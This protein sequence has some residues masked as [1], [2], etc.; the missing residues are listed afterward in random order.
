VRVVRMSCG[1]LLTRGIGRSGGRAPEASAG[2]PY[3]SACGNPSAP[4][5]GTAAFGVPDLVVVSGHVA[6]L[7]TKGSLLVFALAGAAPEGADRETLA[8]A[9]IDA[10]GD[11][12]I[13]MLPAEA[14]AFAFL[15]DGANDGVID[16]GDPIAVLTGPV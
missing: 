5:S 6:A 4:A 3:I 1:F 15:A 8:V 9:A 10:D 16:G 13:T 11:F 14:V 2:S 12:A 7:G